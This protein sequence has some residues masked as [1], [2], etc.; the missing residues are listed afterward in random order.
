ME[1]GWTLV[2][3]MEMEQR[4]M[5]EAEWIVCATHGYQNLK[6]GIE[7]DLMEGIFL[8]TRQLC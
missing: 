8:E 4:Y 6:L 2:E 3:V 5:D 7:F 1:P